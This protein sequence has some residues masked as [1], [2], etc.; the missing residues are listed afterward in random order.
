VTP[1]AFDVGLFLLVT[2]TLVMLIHHLARLV[3]AL[4]HEQ[5]EEAAR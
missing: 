5:E 2:G 4:E 3:E 1:V